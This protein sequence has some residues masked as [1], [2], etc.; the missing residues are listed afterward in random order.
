MLVIKELQM[1]IDYNINPNPIDISKL[2]K[3]Q[4]EFLNGD[5][6]KFMIWAL[7]YLITLEII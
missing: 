2:I 4:N 1:E 5:Y 3:I 7:E 6:E